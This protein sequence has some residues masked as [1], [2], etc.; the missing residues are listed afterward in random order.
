M[1]VLAWTEMSFNSMSFEM[2]WLGK[3][4][5][6]NEGVAGKEMENKRMGEHLAWV[7]LVFFGVAQTLQATNLG[8][9][10][11]CRQDMQNTWTFLI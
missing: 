7:S 8:G 4:N 5:C 10:F 1:Q 2:S 9:G 11:L 6:I 3:M